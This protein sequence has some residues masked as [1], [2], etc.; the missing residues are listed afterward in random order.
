M[1][2]GESDQTPL[3]SLGRIRVP[4]FKTVRRG[5]D[6]GEVMEYLVWVGDHVETLESRVQQLQSESHKDAQGAGAHVADLMRTFDQVDRL[7][8]EADRMVAEAKAEAERIRVDTRFEAEAARADAQRTLR[9]AQREADKI[10][11]E[12][13]SRREAVLNEVGAIREDMLDAA[14]GLEAA[15]EWG[16]ERRWSRDRGG[17]GAGR[18]P[19]PRS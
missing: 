14:R 13:A 11:S 10:L 17:G 19:T 8:R 3:A 16:V 15:I 5:F 1:A 7:R 6:P 9:D 18:A 2:T 12:L 4:R